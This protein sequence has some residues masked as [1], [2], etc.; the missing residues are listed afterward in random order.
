MKEDE[1]LEASCIVLEAEDAL[2]E[3]KKQIENLLVHHDFSEFAEMMRKEAM[4]NAYAPP[5]KDPPWVLCAVVFS[6]AAY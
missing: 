2:P 5:K 3:M 6:S 1:V 4:G